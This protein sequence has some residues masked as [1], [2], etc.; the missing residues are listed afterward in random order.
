MLTVLLLL[1]RTPKIKITRPIIISTLDRMKR[2]GVLI[3]EVVTS[4]IWALVIVV[5]DPSV[6]SVIVPVI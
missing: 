2:V 6:A 5:K 4:D 3:N 1:R